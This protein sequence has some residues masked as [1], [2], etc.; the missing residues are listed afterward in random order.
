MGGPGSGRVAKSRVGPDDHGNVTQY[1]SRG[2]RCGACRE[3]WRNYKRER[4]G[5]R[6]RRRA[7]YYGEKVASRIIR[8]AALGAEILAAIEARTGRTG[9]DVV[10]QLLREH[11]GR[12]AFVEP[13]GDQEEAA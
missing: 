12:V 13:T 11:G 10:E 3:A 7:P 6:S 9:D 5:V 2:C 8:L 1:A 4:A